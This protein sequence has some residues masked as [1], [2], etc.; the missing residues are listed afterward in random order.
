MSS[1]FYVLYC[2]LISVANVIRQ[3][4]QGPQHHMMMGGAL[5][6]GYSES[7][8]KQVYLNL[9]SYLILSVS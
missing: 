1:I 2:V 9:F 6:M 4:Q 8:E 5:L 3:Y 7:L